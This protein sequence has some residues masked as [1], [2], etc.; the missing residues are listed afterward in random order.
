MSVDLSRAK[1]AFTAAYGREPTLGARAPGRVNL[2]GE[3]T[4]YN[5]GFVLPMAI[6][7]DTLLLG[8]PGAA[9]ILNL[10]AANYSRRAAAVVGRWVRNPDEP[11]A[12]YIVGVAAEV[13]QLGRPVAAMDILVMGDVPIGAGLSSSASLEMAALRLFEENAGFVLPPADAAKLGRR[14]ENHFLGIASGIMD[15]FAARSAV[16]GHALFID[17]RSNEATPVPIAFTHARFVIADTALSRGL[18]SSKYNERVAECAAAVDA[19]RRI[20]GRNGTHLRD[21]SVDDLVASAASMPDTPY[22]RARHVISENR[23]VLEAKDALAAGDAARFG[24][25]M[26]ESDASLRDDYEVTSPELDAMT[27]ISRALDGC[28][29]SRMTG[30]G[31]G[32]CTVSLVDAEQVETFCVE[33]SRQYRDATGRCATLITTTAAHGASAIRLA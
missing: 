22:R 18:A 16:E 10:Y 23:R 21:F 25:L 32:G 12:D 6:E 20:T 14:V 15:Q 31:F 19:L 3:H 29:G 1:A 24:R 4:D 28:R 17:C 26:N 7:R 5:H 33:L 11:W 8:A 13:Q 9:G 30:A 27:S 2:I